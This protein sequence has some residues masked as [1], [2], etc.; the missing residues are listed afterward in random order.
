MCLALLAGVAILGHA[1][2][3][4]VALFYMT[5]S[6]DSVRSF[7]AHSDKIGILVP[8]WYSVDANGLVSGGPNPE[9]LQIAQQQHLPVMPR[10]Y[11]RR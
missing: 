3:S 10:T 2:N 7:L 8:T 4:P 1:Q 9:V 5:D 6:P 11:C